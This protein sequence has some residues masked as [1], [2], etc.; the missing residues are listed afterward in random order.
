[1]EKEGQLGK[2]KRAAGK[3]NSVPHKSLFGGR[4]RSL[5]LARLLLAHVSSQG[6]HSRVQTQQVAVVAEAARLEQKGGK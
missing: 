6:V 4:G 2:G 3:S 1:M 5:A